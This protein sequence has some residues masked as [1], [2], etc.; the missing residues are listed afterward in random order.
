VSPILNT[1]LAVVGVSALSLIGLL[2]LSV[3]EQRLERWVPL[4]ASLASGA[5]CGAAGFELI[6]EA[7]ARRDGGAG[8]VAIGVG[9]GFV[10]FAALEMALEMALARGLG[11]P[12]VGHPA[13]RH[14]IVMLNF[15]GDTIHNAADGAM[16]A[17]A[18]LSDRTVGLVTTL[19]IVLHEIPRELG[20]FGVFVHGGLP[21]RQAVWFNGLTGLAAVAGAAV[22][23]VIGT[24]TTGV[25]TMLLP[26]AA[27]T[28]LYIGL[29][30]APTTVFGARSTADR[31]R[32]FALAAVGLAATAAAARIG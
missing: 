23:V 17:A 1:A 4:L 11:S 9:A 7:L 15:I 14:P 8:S 24:G 22:T 31:L 28:F 3:G 6:P 18:F 19:A 25:A 16:I 26:I 10:A 20:S 27:G 30:I 21:V 5:L 13:S 32:R 2:S 29:S 12:S